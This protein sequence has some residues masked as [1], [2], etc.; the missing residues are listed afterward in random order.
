MIGNAV[1]EKWL[2]DEDT[3]TDVPAEKL[4]LKIIKAKLLEHLPQ[5][6]PFQVK[7]ELEYWGESDSGVNIIFIFL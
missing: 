4:A 1:P 2:Y 6:V 3:L 5:E 7:P